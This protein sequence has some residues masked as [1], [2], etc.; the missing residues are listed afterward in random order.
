MGVHG[1]WQLGRRRTARPTGFACLLAIGN[2]IHPS[3]DKETGTGVCRYLCDGVGTPYGKSFA[4]LHV[5][6]VKVV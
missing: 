4:S 6:A 1:N 3:L 5:V 2:P